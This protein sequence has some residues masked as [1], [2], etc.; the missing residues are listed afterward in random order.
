MN[1]D[2]VFAILILTTEVPIHVDMQNVKFI[3]FL[4]WDVI[5]FVQA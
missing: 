3:S 4:I 2:S 1:A 5:V